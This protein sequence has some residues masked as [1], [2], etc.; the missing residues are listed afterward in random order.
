[1]FSE[2]NVNKFL[3]MS[4]EMVRKFQDDVAKLFDKTLG[5]LEPTLRALYARVHR[6]ASVG[7]APKARR[8]MPAPAFELV[9]A[10]FGGAEAAVAGVVK[11]LAPI[12]IETLVQLTPQII[13]M[14]AKTAGQISA[15][16]FSEDNV[17]K[18]LELA[19][20]LFRK[21]NADVSK[22]LDRTLGQL[23]PSLRAVYAKVHRGPLAIADAQF[24]ARRK[25]ARKAGVSKKRRPSA[26]AAAKKKRSARRRYVR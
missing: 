19:R 25:R 5:Q 12:V 22:L 2:D 7:A 24:G 16:V 18:F 23:E 1:V 10:Q 15:V 20:E 4:R 8:L 21:L 26:T 11:I 3:E 9:D 14:G 6:G 17:N 13:E